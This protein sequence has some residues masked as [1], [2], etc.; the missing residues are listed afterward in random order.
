M[1]QGAQFGVVLAAQCLVHPLRVAHIKLASDVNVKGLTLKYRYKT[2]LDCLAR[3]VQCNGWQ[4]LYGSLSF[5]ILKSAIIWLY[6]TNRYNQQQ[7]DDERG[8][9][10]RHEWLQQF[11]GVSL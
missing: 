2:S 5:Y 1:R 8:K 4:G 10:N 11:L 7:A 9:F 3:V 6:H